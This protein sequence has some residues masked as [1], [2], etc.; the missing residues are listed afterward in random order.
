MNE[1]K[2][3]QSGCLCGTIESD[4]PTLIFACS[5]AA[6]VGGVADQ[7]ARKL[8]VEGTGKM[9]CLAAIGGG[10]QSYLE[11]TDKAGK[12]LAIDGCPVDCAKHV[13]EEAGFMEFKHIRLADLGLVKAKTGITPEAIE[14]VAQA[15]RQLII[16]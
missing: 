1:E 13:L 14:I 6:D 9:F 4:G 16:R 2:I 11:S 15:G 5:G 10:I 8:S 12:I 7:A 3:A